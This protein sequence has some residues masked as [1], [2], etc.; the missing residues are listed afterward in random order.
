MSLTAKSD[1]VLVTCNVV[2]VTE[3]RTQH[4][5]AGFPTFRAFVFVLTTTEYLD[6][7]HLTIYRRVYLGNTVLHL[8]A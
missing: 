5:A 1:V 3:S 8:C 4:P 2:V 7:D 6:L